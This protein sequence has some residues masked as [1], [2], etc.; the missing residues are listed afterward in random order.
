MI[1]VGGDL[2][3]ATSEP[4]QI[5]PGAFLLRGFA[6]TESD[7]LLQQIESVAQQA[8]FRHQ[9]T[10]GGHTMS[11][12]MTNCGDLGW[13]T[14]TS[15]YRYSRLDPMT[16]QPWPALPA[17]VLDVAQRAASTAGYSG[18]APQACLINR[19]VTGARMGLHQDKDEQDL[20]AP[21]VSISLGAP[22]HFQFGGLTRQDRYVRWKLEHGDVVVWGG[23][24]RLYYHGV[25]PMGKN[26]AHPVSG[27][28]RYNITLRRVYPT[29]SAST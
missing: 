20:D 26:A 8:P 15:G 11:A 5:G 17:L 2:F 18:F 3:G 1:P 12:A 7:A 29:Q 19:Y 25:A 4:I 6:L 23:E 27:S 22:M 21:I 24:S 9:I 10:P 16:G 13:V 14:D 28:V